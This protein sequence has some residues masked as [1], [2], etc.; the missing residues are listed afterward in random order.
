[1]AVLSIA[2]LGVARVMISQTRYFEHQKSA[3]QARSVPRGPLN[4]IVS[5]LRMVEAT[6]GVV[7]AS[8]SA[9]VVRAPYALGVTCTNVIGNTY[10][11]ILPVDSAM[12]DS[13]GFTGFAY[14]ETD[15]SYTY[16]ES[17]MPL[18]PLL[19]LNL[20]NIP[21]V[22]PVVMSLFGGQGLIVKMPLPLANPPLTLGTPVFLYRTIRY[23]FAPS[24]TIAGSRGL[25][26]TVVATGQTE[27]LSAPF[28]PGAKFRFFVLNSRTPQAVPPVDL[29]TIRGIQ[30]VLD[31]MSERIPSGA[32]GKQKAP[33]TTA[34][35][36]K[37]R[38]DL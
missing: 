28:Q 3:I 10:A 6:G 11:S 36:F 33:F 22:S 19:D 5:D 7:S 12:Y 15:G 20:C 23:S 26:R 35:Y 37:N 8:D 38:P 9:V 1:M 18:L 29:S 25:Y 27:E 24:A 32:T 2:G 14:R 30:L 16:I 21:I 4:R 13:P 17:G 34:I 31:G